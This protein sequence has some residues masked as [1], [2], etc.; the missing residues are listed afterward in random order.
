MPRWV[1]PEPGRQARLGVPA[2]HNDFTHSCLLPALNAARGASTAFEVTILYRQRSPES[3]THSYRARPGASVAVWVF[4]ANAERLKA[5]VSRRWI[6]PILSGNFT[7]GM[8]TVGAPERAASAA[9]AANVSFAA[10]NAG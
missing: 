2:P 9:L 3:R 1:P 4:A 5:P 10:A 7:D 8:E 6:Q